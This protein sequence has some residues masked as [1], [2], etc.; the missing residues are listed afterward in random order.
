M[1]KIVS[2]PNLEITVCFTVDE[3][4]ARALDALAGYGDDA[5]IKVFYEKLG[6][7]YM[8]EHEAGLRSFLKSVRSCVRP[9]ID[10]VSNARKLL[11][12][13]AIAQNKRFDELHAKTGPGA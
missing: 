6:K 2:R 9:A 12:E 1:A 3:A 7:A 5:F 4:E 13:D 8:E 10:M 11:L